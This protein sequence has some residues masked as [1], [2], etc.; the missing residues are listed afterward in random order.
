MVYNDIGNYDQAEELY[1]D[2]LFKKEKTLG[3]NHPD[4]LLIVNNL[5]LLYYNKGDYEKAEPLFVKALDGFKKTLDLND[6]NIRVTTN[7]LALAYTELGNTD[8]AIEY[9]NILIELQETHGK[10]I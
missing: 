5:G 4:T 10:Q 2:V 8:K 9:Y 3:P 7:N 6:E 1:N